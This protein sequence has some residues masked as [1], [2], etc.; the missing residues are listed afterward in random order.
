MQCEAKA[1][2]TGKQCQRSA[3]AGLNVCRVHG[4]NTKLARAAGVRRMEEAKSAM[5]N[6]LPEIAAELTRIALS[7][8]S[9]AVR[10]QATREVFARLGFGEA[11]KV[12]ISL[13]AA[14][15][16]VDAEIAR[17]S[18]QLDDIDA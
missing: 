9:E 4:G 7:A 17:L 2:S 18:Q 8:E 15:S 11:D 5:L 14:E 10:V 3:K 1:K 6:G 16:R 12:E 13:A